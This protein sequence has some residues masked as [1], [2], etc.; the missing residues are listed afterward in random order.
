M[1]TEI[2]W[3]PLSTPGRL[4]IMPR[5]RGGDWLEDE[6]RAWRNV[7]VNIVLSL[8]TPDEITDLDL[9]QEQKLAQ[10]LGMEF[11][12]FPIPDRAVPSLRS[13]VA[14]IASDSAKQ[15]TEGKNVVVHCRQGIGRAALIAIC[16]MVMTGVDVDDAI[17]RVSS[18]RGTPVPETIDQK[19]WIMEFAKCTSPV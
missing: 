19:K 6:L 14:K 11:H 2:F 18:A 4:A 13:A 1:K 17:E 3:I 7:G 5:P 8:L 16:V 10:S 12:S 15:L 9:T